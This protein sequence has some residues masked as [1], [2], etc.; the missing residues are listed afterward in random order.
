M[1]VM[2]AWLHVCVP[3]MCIQ[4]LPEV[5]R[6]R[7]TSGCEQPCGAGNWTLSSARALS[8]LNHRPISSVSL[9]EYAL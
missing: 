5:K 2:C 4:E 7:V 6:T 9:L 3:E 1:D 8:V